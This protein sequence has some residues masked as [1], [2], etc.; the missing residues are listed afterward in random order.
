MKPCL[1]LMVI[2]FSGFVSPSLAFDNGPRVIGCDYRTNANDPLK[3]EMCFIPSSGTQMGITH[4]VIRPGQSSLYYR[5]EDNYGA[6]R[7]KAE[8][9]EKAKIQAGDHYDSPTQWQGVFKQ[10]GGHCRPGG[11]DASIYELSNGAKFC[12]Y[13]NN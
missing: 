9:W 11:A 3:A 12:L 7:N 13:D 6:T 1:A 10:R 8:R 2:G 5:L 4:L